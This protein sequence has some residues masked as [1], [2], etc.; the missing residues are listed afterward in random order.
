MDGNSDDKKIYI[1]VSQTGTIISKLLKIITRKEY[2]HSSISLKED[3]SIMYS[4]GRLNPYN[5]FLGGFV[6]EAPN[7]GTFKR[8]NKTQ[9]IVLCLDIDSETH[10]NIQLHIDSMLKEKVSERR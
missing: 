7:Y 2:N 4:F 1:V 9:A 10:N 6:I 8:F 3:L 5:P